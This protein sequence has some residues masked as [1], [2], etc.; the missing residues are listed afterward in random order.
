MYNPYSGYYPQN[1]MR[2]PM[3]Q[4]QP[5]VTPPVYQQEQAAQ[6]RVIPVANPEEATAI[7]T[8]FSG[9]PYLMPDFAH[10]AIYTKTFNQGTGASVFLT[11]RLEENLQ[12]NA[13]AAPVPYDAKAEI[14]KLTAELENIKKKLAAIEPEPVQEA[15][16]K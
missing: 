1:N 10:G 8:D 13:Q 7:P 9:I 12:A 2:S 6:F 11:F 15:K 3:P 4:V 5:V 16:K 14:D